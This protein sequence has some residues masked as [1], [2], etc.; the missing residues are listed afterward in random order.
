MSTQSPPAERAQPATEAA[1]RR[2]PLAMRLLA[3][4]RAALHGGLGEALW[5]FVTLR[6][7]LSALAWTIARLAPMPETCDQAGYIPGH[8]QGLDLLLEGVWLR[9]DACWYEK[10]AAFGYQRGDPSVNFLPLFPWLQRAGGFLFGGNLTLSGLV[11]TGLAYIVALTGL[12]RLITR[13]FDEAL[14]RNTVLYISIFPTAFFFFAPFSEA[15]FLCLAVWAIL[16]AREERWGWVG[17][18]ALLCGLVRVQGVVLA[19]PLA[20]EAFQQWRAGR[21]RWL[22]WLAVTL[23]PLSFALLTL[24]TKLATGTTTFETQSV[25]WGN[26]LRWPW[27]VLALSWREITRHNNPMEVLNLLTVVL[28]CMALLAG[29]RRLPISYTIF[30]ATQVFLI[31]LHENFVTPLTGTLRYALVLFPVF[32]VLASWGLR[33]RRLHYSWLILSLALIGVLLYA[34][35]TGPFVS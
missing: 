35:L 12:Y 5:L 25:V 21:R 2:A 18:L 9:W 15:L 13:D 28:C 7:V 30:A 32:V 34:F 31:L 17:A 3:G 24:Y 4:E 11:V 27:E 23:A 29:V 14:A 33:S 10:V 19:L 22:A 8:R 1:T 20:W 6:V 26:Q 16:L